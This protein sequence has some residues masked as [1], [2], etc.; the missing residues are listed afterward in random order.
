MGDVQDKVLK[1]WSALPHYSGWSSC[2]TFPRES[3]ICI[4][5]FPRH[6]LYS[7]LPDTAQK[8]TIF[9]LDCFHLSRLESS[10]PSQEKEY[11]NKLIK[12][13]CSKSLL[14]VDYPLVENLNDVTTQF[15]QR[16]EFSINNFQRVSIRPLIYPLVTRNPLRTIL[17]KVTVSQWSLQKHRFV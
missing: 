6:Q 15:G 2:S 12:H 14:P 11:V 13:K 1:L 16:H 4:T 17:E 10:F 5:F 8:F 9:P 3:D 7:Q